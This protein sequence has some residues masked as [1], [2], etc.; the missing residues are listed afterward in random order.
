MKERQL[1]RMS[2]FL[3]GQLRLSPTGAL[4][5]VGKTRLMVAHAGVFILRQTAVGA[6]I[7]KQQV[8]RGR[9]NAKEI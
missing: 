3:W 7:K 8:W 5:G 2:R 1:I 9:P 6:C 4:G